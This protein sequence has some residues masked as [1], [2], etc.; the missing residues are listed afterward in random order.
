MKRVAQKYKKTLSKSLRIRRRK[1]KLIQ[2]V[3]RFI[4]NKNRRNRRILFKEWATY[5]WKRYNKTLKLHGRISALDINAVK[6]IIR[7]DNQNPKYLLKYSLV[8]LF[9]FRG[10]E[11]RR[12]AFKFIPLNYFRKVNFGNWRYFDDVIRDG[13][14]ENNERDVMETYVE[15][16]I[17]YSG[18]D[19]DPV[20]HYTYFNNSG[21]LKERFINK[22]K[23]TRRLLRFFLKKGCD[24][25]DENFIKNLIFKHKYHCRTFFLKILEMCYKYGLEPNT[26]I[27]VLKEKDWEKEIIGITYYIGPVLIEHINRLK[28]KDTSNLCMNWASK[29]NFLEAITYNKGSLSNL[30]DDVI[31]VITSFVYFI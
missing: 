17:T 22:E 15:N 20:S 23:T 6:S 21:T 2:K 8:Q 13:W 1:Q 29:K 28:V 19:N 18:S 11:N 7:K 30:N 16:P 31:G 24:P 26:I 3:E 5:A 14:Y 27:K 4:Q 9:E 25:N 10:R 12:F